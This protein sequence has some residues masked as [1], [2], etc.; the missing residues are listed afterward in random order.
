LHNTLEEGDDLELPLEYIKAKSNKEVSEV[1][2][3]EL[4]AMMESFFNIYDPQFDVGGM[5]DVQNLYRRLN[6]TVLFD[7]S[8]DIGSHLKAGLI[9]ILNTEL[10]VFELKLKIQCGERI[11]LVKDSGK[12]LCMFSS[13]FEALERTYGDHMI[14]EDL[15]GRVIYDVHGDSPW[16]VL[17]QITNYYF[18]KVG[19]DYEPFRI[20]FSPREFKALLTFMKHQMYVIM[21]DMS[22]LCDLGNSLLRDIMSKVRQTLRFN[23]KGCTENLIIQHTC[24][25]CFLD[26]ALAKAALLKQFAASKEDPMNS[27]KCRKHVIAAL[28]S[29]DASPVTRH[30]VKCLRS[31]AAVTRRFTGGVPLYIQPFVTPNR[32]AICVKYGTDDYDFVDCDCD[33]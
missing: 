18:H 7:S 19:I 22:T 5:F 8:F 17:Y 9:V 30:I 26:H 4:T 11:L 10:C 31:E 12:F 1:G 15:I 14:F 24:D 21:A 28:E 2:I 23:C 16:L 6:W 20:V 13:S 25:D 33:C 29:M 32:M 27:D 3:H